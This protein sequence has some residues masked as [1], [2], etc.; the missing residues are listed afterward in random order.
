MVYA[1]KLR[2]EQDYNDIRMK[3]VGIS[4]KQKEQI[5]HYVFQLERNE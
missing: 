1:G 5:I 3:Y 2:N 4:E